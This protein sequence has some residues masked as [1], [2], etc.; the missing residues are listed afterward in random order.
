[1][2]AIAK[3]VIENLLK[4]TALFSISKV[5]IVPQ[6]ASHHAPLPPGK[7]DAKFLE[8]GEINKC[9]LLKINYNSRHTSLSGLEPAR[10]EPY[11]GNINWTCARICQ[12]GPSSGVTTL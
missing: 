6:K 10:Q 8:T 11:L 9:N 4:R 7:G 2:P 12:S 5:R 1:M 3:G